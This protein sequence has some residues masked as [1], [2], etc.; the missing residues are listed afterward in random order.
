MTAPRIAEHQ[1][2]GFLGEI[3]RL[4]GVEV[5]VAIARGH[6]GRRLY[7]PEKV[8]PAHPLVRL[9]GSKAARL[10][11]HHFGG[12]SR[13]IPAART[14]LR[15]YDVRRLRDQAFTV[16]EISRRLGIGRRQV[17]E[18]LKGYEPAAGVEPEAAP[19]R[20]VCPACGRRCGTRHAAPPRDTRQ[21][22]LPLVA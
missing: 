22:T 9:V 1:L 20:E 13:D 2:P 14:Y 17:S 6:G 16:A 15:W 3:A 10:I 7:L 11:C 8:K 18:L 21:L 4:A 5:A 12:E 19:A